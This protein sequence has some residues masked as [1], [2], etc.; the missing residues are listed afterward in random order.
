MYIR[1]IC[2]Y[3]FTAI[4]DEEERLLWTYPFFQYLQSFFSDGV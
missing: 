3:R 1:T 4:M 2:V